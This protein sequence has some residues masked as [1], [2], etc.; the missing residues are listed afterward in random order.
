MNTAKSIYEASLSKSFKAKLIQAPD[1]VKEFYS[2]L[3]NEVLSYKGTR[4]RISWHFDSIN[5]KR[6]QVLKFVIKG[7]TL[8]LYY[9]LNAS[10][11]LDTKFK[12]EKVGAVRYKDV[13][14]LYRIKNKKRVRYAKELIADVAFNLSLV[15]GKQKK[16]N[17]GQIPYESNESLIKK[18]LIK[19]IKK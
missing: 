3:K 15:K 10:S 16:E 11:Y 6:D 14:C 13:P 17:Y 7:K 2:E 18:G 4:S 12:V 19:E 9:P 5:S 8:C 1:E